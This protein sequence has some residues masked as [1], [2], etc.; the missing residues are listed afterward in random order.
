MPRRFYYLEVIEMISNVSGDERGKL[1][2]GRAGDQTGNEWK[3]R[4][5]YNRPWLCVLRHPDP[6]VRKELATLARAGALN[7]LIG[8][9]Q[10][11]VGNSDD[12]YSFWVQLKASN[13]D[14]A[15]IKK[16]CETDCSAAEAAMAKAV[17]Y[18]L[19]IDKLK[20]ISI[21]LYTG[22]MRAAFKAAGFQVLTDSKYLTSD[23]YLLEGDVLLNDGHHV[24]TNLDNGSKAGAGS[25]SGSESS[26]GSGGTT[27]SRE[28]K[29]TGYV[30]ADA[31]NVRTWAGTENGTCS[32]SPLYEGEAVEVCDT[33]KANTGKDWYYIR[34]KVNGTYKYGFVSSTYI[35]KQAPEKKASTPAAP[36]AGNEA[37]IYKYLTGTMGLNAAAACGVLANI[38]AESGMQSAIC[39]TL[40]LNRLKEHGKTYTSATYTAAVDSGKISRA[41][42]LNPLPGKQYG[43]G[44]VQWTSP[45]RKAGLY[46]LAKKKGVSIGDMNM[47]LEYLAAELSKNYASVLKY[48]KAVPNTVQGAYDAAYRW[49]AKYEIPAN[50]AATAAKRGNLAKGTYWPKYK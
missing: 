32:F 25:G 41:E 33:I 22:N 34:K 19:N 35:V 20:N 10:G 17:G 49:C 46:D 30:N 6:A 27:L 14:P 45:G 36:A 23:A 38:Q 43:Y 13:Y 4:S 24:A 7:D 11:T 48:I 1:A 9:D 42:F 8:Y 31:L 18:R 40:C 12:R 29:W 50:T 3:I 5:W 28:P 26:S 15:Q 16:A 47:Q 44:L 37:I 21:Y 2:G 39:E